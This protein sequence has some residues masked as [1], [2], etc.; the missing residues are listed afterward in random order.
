MLEQILLNMMM[1]N[2][3]LPLLLLQNQLKLNQNKKKKPKLLLLQLH[4][5][6]FKLLNNPQNKMLLLK[7]KL[8]QP[9]P[10]LIFQW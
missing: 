1:I 7:K 2:L 9:L 4:L 5:L 3:Q 8:L 6:P 10:L